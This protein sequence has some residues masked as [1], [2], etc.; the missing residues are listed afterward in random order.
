MARTYVKKILSQEVAKKKGNNPTVEELEYTIPNGKTFT[1]ERF[2]GG[3]EDAETEVRVELVL[4]D[5]QNDEILF[6]GY[7]CNFDVKDVETVEGDGSKKIV[8]RLINGDNGVLHMTGIW[9]G[10]YNG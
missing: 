2:Y 7:A 8:L 3:R 10:V 9:R 5:G 4:R 1:I 6:V